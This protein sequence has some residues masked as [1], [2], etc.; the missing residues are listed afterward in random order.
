MLENLKKILLFTA[1]PR[2]FVFLLGVIG[3]IIFIGKWKVFLYIWL[4][5]DSSEILLF[6]FPSTVRYFQKGSGNP[7]K[8]CKSVPDLGPPFYVKIDQN[9]VPF[10]VNKI[11]NKVRQSDM[12]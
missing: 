8:T 1:L 7:S 12:L 2:C 9:Y 6:S 10:F 5:M 3:V 11:V 4:N